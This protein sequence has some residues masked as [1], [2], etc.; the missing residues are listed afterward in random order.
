MDSKT[1]I[2]DIS[3]VTKAKLTYEEKLGSR[4]RE[5]CAIIGM[6]NRNPWV[7]NLCSKILL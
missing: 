6:Q 1:I 4:L 2:L 5:L 3:K 7:M